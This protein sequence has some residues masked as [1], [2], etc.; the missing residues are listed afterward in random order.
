MQ[1]LLYDEDFLFFTNIVCPFTDIQCLVPVGYSVIYKP[2]YQ[3]RHNMTSCKHC[4]SKNMMYF[5]IP[6]QDN[7]TTVNVNVG[8]S[9]EFTFITHLQRIS[10]FCLKL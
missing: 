1:E 10:A 2:W 5:A 7:W 3:G 4:K 6:R 9:Q 8:K